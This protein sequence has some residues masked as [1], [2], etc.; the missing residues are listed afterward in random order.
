MT[1]RSSAPVVPL[2]RSRAFPATATQIRE[3]RQFLHRA[4]GDHP[5]IDDAV[6]CVSEMATNA[7]VHSRSREPGGQFVVKAARSGTRIRVE[8]RD[9]GGSWVHVV[10]QEK[11]GHG[12]HIISQIAARWGIDGDSKTGWTVWA[13]ILG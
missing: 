7:A 8:V 12:L 6:L 4:F 13:E 1:R 5:A 3:A 9:Q 10:G 2:A 11:R